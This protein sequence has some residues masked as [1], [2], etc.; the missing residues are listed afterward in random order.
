M[1]PRLRFVLL[2][3]LLVTSSLAFFAIAS[4]AAFAWW[5]AAHALNDAASEVRKASTLPFTLA[6]LHPPVSRSESISAPADYRAAAIF[7]G[8]LFLC[9]QSAL[10]QL[11][12]QGRKTRE[13]RAGLELPPTSLTTLAVRRGIGTPE[14]WVGTAREGILIFDGQ[15]TRQL[16]P[17]SI[18]LRSV[19]ALLPLADG[20][21]L[22]GTPAAGL[23][24]SDGKQF[25]LFHTE[26]AQAQV[27]ALAGDEDSVWVGTRAQGAW[28]WRGG[29]ISRYQDVLPDAQ[30]LSI[31]SSG[32]TT[33]I[34]TPVG[35]AEFINGHFERKLA[36]GLFAQAL[37]EWNGSL[38]VSTVD[39]GTVEVPLG[40][41]RLSRNPSV[42]NQSV[43]AFVTSPDNLFA[44]ASDRVLALP[45]GNEIVSPNLEA[46]AA[47]HITALHVDALDHLWIGYF[48]HG[49]DLYPLHSTEG[50]RHLEDDRVFCVNRIKESPDRNTV[51]V[52]TA[53]GLLLFDH[54]GR[55]RQT[56]TRANGLIADHV[57]DV[58]FGD[59]GND[60]MIVATPAGLTFV[61]NGRSS[62][63]YAFQ[64]LVNNHVYTISQ[65]NAPGTRELF[66]GTLGGFSVLR[67]RAVQASFTT[68]N[69][70]LQ[71]NWITAS[72]EAWGSLYLG[73]YGSGV[74]RLTAQGELQSFREFSGREGRVEINPNAMIATQQAL[75]VGT[76][77]RGL[78]VLRRN[79]ERWTFITD[80]LPSLNVTAIAN[81]NNVLYVG[82]DNG[83]VRTRE[84]L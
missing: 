11:D 81:Q 15:S 47:A 24:V 21:V 13:W 31:A 62:S 2:R 14:L 64:G 40:K 79:A 51:A 33:W 25:A 61:Q 23:F 36:G 35:V 8:S 83:L 66:A 16:L 53:N 52:A 82:T 30:V 65:F 57:T 37:A 71:Q 44:I 49:L 60:D 43:V 72:T 45:S 22:I 76:A 55:L 19:S 78:A 3:T 77:G 9:G 54:S 48:D 29:Q 34:G 1:Q 41:Q 59:E 27:T 6:P 26:F 28:R 46:L 38:F 18:P 20:R 68:A 10:I 39:E 70:E 7:E 75:Y 80:G 58:L 42:T 67:D 4:I 50:R 12:K 73:T 56:L 74:V 84:A 63:I 5:R 17:D 69:S 32:Q